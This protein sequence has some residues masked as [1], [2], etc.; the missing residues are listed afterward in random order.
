MK[1][2]LIA[3]TAAL[4]IAMPSYAA[5][6]QTANVSASIGEA[7]DLSMSIFQLDS[8]GNPIGSNL[9]T[10]IPFGELVADTTFG[11][12]H[13]NAAYTVYLGANSSSRPYTIKSTLP[14]LSNGTTTLP[15]AMVMVVVSAKSGAD[16]I[17]GDSYTPG[18]QNA[19]MSNQ[20]IYTSN[21][22]GTGAF[23]Q[24]VYGISGGNADGT[25]PFPG[26]EPIL[27]GQASGSY[28]ASVQYTI[29]LI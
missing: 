2:T 17:S 4:A 10:S 5:T 6:T 20:T 21:G 18:G 26:W 1:K 15:P 9:G 25:D 23:V 3:L 13:G 11:V 28:T 24:L 12:M 7:L 8:V 14:A 19:I 27:L 16:D 29:S 22:A